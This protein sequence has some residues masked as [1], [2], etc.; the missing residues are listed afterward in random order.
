MSEPLHRLFQAAESID[1]SDIHLSVGEPAFLRV[2]GKLVSAKTEPLTE[3]SI[4]DLLGPTLNQDRRDEYDRQ[5]YVDFAYE[6]P[7]TIAPGQT[8]AIRYRMHLY[9]CRGHLT[10]ALRRIKLD[11]PTFE[12]LFLPPVYEKAITLRPK[13]IIIIGG[14][15]GSGKSTSLAAML[16]Y[17]NQ[18]EQKH[19]VTIEDPIE[20]VLQNKKC[21][22][23]Q[24]ELGQDFATFPA[25]LR[26]VVR[27]DPDIILI[28]ELRDSESVRAAVAAAETGHL[29][30]T[31]LHTASAPEAL[32][33]ILYFFP[34]HE[35]EAV[36]HNLANT[37]IA[38]MNQM[39][40][41][42]NDK[43]AKEHGV[44]RVPATEVLLST[45][46]VKEFL[47]DKERESGLTDLIS[48]EKDC[49]WESSHDFNFSLKRLVMN[50]TVEFDTALRASLR[51]EALRMTLK[52]LR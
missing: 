2:G 34:P 33:R 10:A 23:N 36:R 42:A 43:F 49:D 38:I 12:Q 27:E 26:A 37:L 46:V 22:I 14:E 5:G 31:S 47:R 51:P 29:V 30:L 40:I 48:N 9:R 17:I 25:A 28:G 16:N 44:R 45:P 24:R 35:E 50:S 6:T 4:L 18:R 32:N 3:Q 21:K 39:L 15:T 19:I 20:F 8:K 52:G 7:L 41:P 1:A 11:I 13:G